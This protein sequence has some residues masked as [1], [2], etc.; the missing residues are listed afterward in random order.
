MK[1]SRFAVAAQT[2]AL[3]GA[4]AAVSLLA[5][6]ATAQSAF[7][8]GI[9]SDAQDGATPVVQR[10]PAFAVRVAGVLRVDAV[11][12]DI[13]QFK[14][15]LSERSAVNFR[16][17]NTPSFNLFD[18]RRDVAIIGSATADNGL[19]YGF[20]YDVDEDRA[21]LYLANRFGR[22][23]MGNTRT[24][25]DALD[26]S[27]ASVMVGRGW[28]NAGGTKNTIAMSGFGMN[29][30]TITRPAG[31]DS[32]RDLISFDQGGGTFRY[33][34]PNYGGLTVSVS[35]TEESDGTVDQSNVAGRMVD[36]SGG[37]EDVVSLG[38][39]YTSSYGNYTT[40]V[41]GGYEKSNLA[42]TFAAPNF[43][44]PG[45][46]IYSAGVKAS[47]NGIAI[48]AGFGRSFFDEL[49]RSID[50][51]DR[52]WDAAISYR[53]GPWALSG[54]VARH[55]AYA[56]GDYE[57]TRAYS[58]SSQYALAPGLSLSAG[59]TWWERQDLELFDANTGMIGSVPDT[60]STTFTIST[61]MSF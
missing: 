13:G 7:D 53:S 19:S 15:L 37:F 21:A 54:G 49:L 33:T 52:W 48:A 8:V 9:I 12:T 11:W 25:T 2:G 56:L 31:S 5:G 44:N 32:V 47:G 55:V 38:V 27:G 17:P 23:D 10:Q 41:Y 30:V 58:M 43:T 34:T 57:K 28:W 14:T 51:Y 40:V 35:Y 29:E 6:P 42:V 61:T 16:L 26:V 39:Q 50:I 60:S 1:T 22:I 20:T 24:G 18:E 59:A 36:G 46:K 3:T 4:L 45:Y